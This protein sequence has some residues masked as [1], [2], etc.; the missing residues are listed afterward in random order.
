MVVIYINDGFV[1]LQPS[2]TQMCMQA[3]VRLHV[4]SVCK[5]W[6]SQMTLSFIQF[7][8]LACCISLACRIEGKAVIAY[9]TK[10]QQ[11]VML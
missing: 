10:V 6:T 4:E 5:S 8:Y 7:R 9:V 3:V 11:F 1:Q 2:L